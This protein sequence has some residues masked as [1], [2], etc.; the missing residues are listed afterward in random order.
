MADKQKKLSL[1]FK[2]LV[3]EKQKKIEFMNQVRRYLDPT[4]YDL[5]YRF[6]L[7][8]DSDEYGINAVFDSSC[9]NKIAQYSIS[10]LSDIINPFQAWFSL[11]V[12]KNIYEGDK[13]KKEELM[14]WGIGGGSDLLSY[15]NRSTYYKA[16]IPDKKS[17]DL[18]GFSG[19]TITANSE[20]NGIRVSS[21]DPFKL[22]SYEDDDGIIGV[23]W[24][25]TF[26]P[27]TMKKM[28]NY[29]AK[30]RDGVG[31]ETEYE[32]VCACVPNKPEFVENCDESKGKYVQLF[33]LKKM[34]LK[35]KTDDKLDDARISDAGIEDSEEI[36]E[37]AYFSNLV[38]T[39][40]KDEDTHRDKYG[41]GWGKKILMN[42]VNMNIIR[43]NLLRG[44]EY[45]GNPAFM[46]PPDYAERYRQFRPG[47]VYGMSYTGQKIEAIEVKPALQEQAFFLG[48]E[49]EELDET[50]PNIAPQ[51]K[52][53]R[54][55]QLEVQKMLLESSKNSFIY[56]LN[57]LMGGVT[58][59]LKKIFKIAYEQGY[60]RKLP[61]G[62]KFSDVEPSLANI[63]LKEFRKQKARSYVE[64]IQLAV[65]YLSSYQEGWDNYKKDF[66]L[67]AMAEGVGG[68]DG[69]ETNDVVEQIRKIRL[70]EYDKQQNQQAQMLDAQMKLMGAQAGKA[71]SEAQRARAETTQADSIERSL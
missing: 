44:T 55:S 46:M 29:D 30:K 10:S 4:Y 57:Y 39:V 54:Q 21:E 8:A 53:Q 28:F 2:E 49:K 6:N 48:T 51:Q 9:S 31:V 26:T 22:L 66:I 67:R 16:L 58:E 17:Y 45:V 7:K 56:K 65:P 15:I 20:N 36:G 52:K 47:Q 12:S 40:V 63:I 23:F 38:T 69:L 1:V 13:D 24:E 18:Y 35:S 42:A 60:V 25:K 41:S 68:D 59:H 32:V 34:T 50:I 70:E 64:M 71:S 19:M 3:S 11:N 5:L 61:E 27:Y 33:I 37:R 62:I 43:R 14:E